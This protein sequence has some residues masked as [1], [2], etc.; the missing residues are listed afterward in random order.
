MAGNPKVVPSTSPE[1]DGPIFHHPITTPYPNCMTHHPFVHPVD[2]GSLQL[3]DCYDK[4]HVWLNQLPAW[5]NQEKIP[6][7]KA[8][9]LCGIPG[10]GKH[11][12]VRT[13][14]RKLARP[15][16]R[17][18][19]AC[20]AFALA[21]ILGLLGVEAPCVLWIDRPEQ[22]HIGVIRWLLD[23]PA[24]PLYLA[25]TTDRPHML[26]LDFLRS[27]VIESVWHLDLPDASHRSKWWDGIIET[28]DPYPGR[29]DGTEPAR[30]SELLTP[31]EIQAAYDATMRQT[32]GQLPSEHDL[33]SHAHD[34]RP[35]VHCCSELL[36]T[37]RHWAATHATNGASK[38]WQQ[39]E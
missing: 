26:P 23:H 12:V 20:D 9:V 1:R 2:P 29:Y 36:A 39:H 19:P 6:A 3:P 34:I 7:P 25:V 38:A 14:A 4:L 37:L 8:T 27:D 30:L 31:G 21:E 5:F 10:S 33:K 16:Y 11:L 35:I 13:I 17:L 24:R 28:P 22:T 32:G 18:D 15:L